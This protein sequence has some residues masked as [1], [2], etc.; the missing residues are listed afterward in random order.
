MVKQPNGARYNQGSGIGVL[1]RSGRRITGFLFVAPAVIFLLLIS[2][3]PIINSI[4]ISVTAY[5][6]ANPIHPFIGLTNY[7]ALLH[8]SQLANSLKNS[9]LLGFFG[10][11]LAF[12]TGL[13]M[14]LLVSSNW[15]PTRVRDVLRGLLVMPWIIS[16]TLAALMWGLMLNGS[17]IIDSYLVRLGLIRNPIF[18]IGD[19]TYALPSIIVIFAWKVYP[20]CLVM[21]VSAMKSVPPEL[22]DAAKVDGA[23]AWEQIRYVTLPMIIPVLLTVALLM[24]M[25]GFGQYDLIRVMT[26][27]GPLEASNVVSYYLYYV[28]FLASKFSY[29]AA[30]SI[31]VFAILLLMGIVYVRL[32]ARSRPWG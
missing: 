8:D 24:F 14:A 12:V 4:L 19:T 15:A 27:G 28:A 10:C 26:S 3:F 11:G 20:F 22:Y 30:I 31:L 16:T 6:I 5:S 21:A 18:F 23:G 7:V 25:W 17:G 9:F 32:Y 2:V 1:R 13:A 29:G